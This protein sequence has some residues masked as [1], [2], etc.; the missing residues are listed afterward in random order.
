MTY[1]LYYFFK[2]TISKWMN[3]DDEYAE[4]RIAFLSVK[5]VSGTVPADLMTPVRSVEAGGAGDCFFYSI[6]DA[7]RSQGLLERTTTDLRIPNTKEEFV[8]AFRALISDNSDAEFL[9]LYRQIC[10]LHTSEYHAREPFRGHIEASGHPTWLSDLILRTFLSYDFERHEC[11]E[12]AD[13]SVEVLTFIREGKRQIRIRGKYTSNIEP[14]I[15]KQLLNAVCI[16]LDIKNRLW[17][18]LLN[19]Q[20]RIVLHNMREGH[21]QYYKF[22]GSGRS[23]D[24]TF[25]VVT[26]NSNASSASPSG[27]LTTASASASASAKVPVPPTKVPI[28][29]TP[30]ANG[31]ISAK[32]PITPTPPANGP[33]KVPITPTPPANGPISVKAP[34]PPANVPKPSA[35]TTP[36]PVS[37]TAR[38]TKIRRT[39]TS[40]IDRQIR[41]VRAAYQYVLDEIDKYERSLAGG[42]E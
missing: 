17:R 42:P 11:I 40:K 10:E 15:A 5:E 25:S 20:N 35:N 36:K 12:H 22:T 31:P 39:H 18:N 37:K 21:Y 6:Y 34:V 26:G 41:R 2:N 14:L 32:V 7:L 24:D 38:N 30:P 9:K 3:S 1:C 19:I 28:T 23:V 16:Y 27:S 13:D 8:I 4:D 33:A 29:P